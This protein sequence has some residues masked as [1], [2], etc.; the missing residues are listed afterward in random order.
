MGVQIHDWLRAARPLAHAN[1]APPL[2]LG[3]AFAWA[4]TGRFSWTAAAL[5]HA[6]GVVDHLFI[7]FANDYAD[8][9]TDADNTT[10]TPFSG[11]SRVIAEGRLSP[12]ALRRAAVAMAA[13]LVALAGAWSGSR[14]GMVA[15]AFVALGLLW[16]YSYPP[17]RYAHRAEGA[18]L[19]GLGVGVILPLVGF[20][21]QTGSLAAFPWSALG[22]LFLLGTAGNVV[23]ALP[24]TPSDRRAGKRTWAVRQ[25]VAR[26]RTHAVLV[27]ALAVVLS[28]FVGPPLP[29]GARMCLVAVPATAVATSLFFVRRA[30]PDHRGAMLGF[31]TTLGGAI[32]LTWVTWAVALFID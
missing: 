20:Y 17:L 13:S 18:L 30:A 23:T 3:Q 9:D 16:A 14:P 19:Q 31:V 26:A 8:R 6:F 12:D 32:A 5:I 7:V 22:P 10:Y 1:V 11:G 21:G 25:G 27:V 28:G 24:D 4:T 2:V 15:F 29:P